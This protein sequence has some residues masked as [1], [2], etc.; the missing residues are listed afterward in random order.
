[1]HRF[2]TWV[3][4]VLCT[5]CLCFDPHAKNK[6]LCTW[7]HW[8]DRLKPHFW[9]KRAW[10]EQPFLTP[11]GS[12]QDAQIISRGSKDPGLR[13]RIN[14]GFLRLKLLFLA[15]AIF[16]MPHFKSRWLWSVVFEVGFAKASSPKGCSTFTFTVKGLGWNLVRIEVFISPFTL[17]V[18]LFVRLHI[19]VTVST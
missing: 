10:T 3:C 12:G 8:L 6:R 1:M 5:V 15:H 18:K 19:R 9:G 7:C 4:D 11:L 16:Q 14:Q 13:L 2:W 17:S